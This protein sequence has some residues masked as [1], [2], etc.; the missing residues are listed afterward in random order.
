MATHPKLRKLAFWIVAAVI[1]YLASFVAL[2]WMDATGVIMVKQNHFAYRPL[3]V[4]Y[5]PARI[6]FENTSVYIW[7]TNKLPEQAEKPN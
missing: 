4:C 6:V 7:I 2:A 3:K 1:V 5:T